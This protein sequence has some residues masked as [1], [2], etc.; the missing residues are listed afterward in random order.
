MTLGRK[1]L[2]RMAAVVVLLFVVSVPLGDRHHGLGQHSQAVADAGQ[3][4]FVMALVS[5]AALIVLSIIALVQFVLRRR[6]LS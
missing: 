1:L 4:L 5:A 6:A 3:T 2:L